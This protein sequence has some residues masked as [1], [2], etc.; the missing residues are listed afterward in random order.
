MITYLLPARYFVAILQSVFLAGN[1][2][3]V[4]LPSFCV[5]AV[6][7]V[8]LRAPGQYAAVLESALAR[9]G[10]PAYFDP[11]TRRPDPAGRAFL[12]LLR[13]ADEGLSARRF[14]EYLSLC[15]VP[16][17]GEDGGPPE[18]SVWVP[19]D[20]EAPGFGEEVEA[21]GHGQAPP[22]LLVP[23]LWERML[24]EASVVGGMPQRWEARLRALD[25]EW[26]RGMERL[27]EEDPDDPR[28]EGLARRRGGL[29]RLRDFALP[30]VEDLAWLPREERWGTWSMVLEPLAS[31]VLRSPHR[32]LSVLADLRPMAEVGPMDLAGVIRVLQEHLL[33]LP[34]EPPP[35]RHGRIFVGT[36]ESLRGRAFDV[37]FIPGL[38]ERLFPQKPGEDPLLPDS[39]AQQLSRALPTRASRARRDRLMLRLAVGA[40]K[41][42]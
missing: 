41:R 36:P 33:D 35:T 8:A 16:A 42:F 2:W 7:A 12:A 29:R 11:G 6:M 18:R 25:A 34:V 26:K 21:E 17:L 5:L 24:V 1:V 23:R 32:V 30:V 19:P 39:L 20:R 38:A 40:G 37:V 3:A 22:D 28:I 14:A 27:R 13:C 31:R 4:F 10:V 9:A 15:Q